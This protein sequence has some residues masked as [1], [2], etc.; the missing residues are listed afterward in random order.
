MFSGEGLF[1]TQ[2]SG[3][4]VAFIT[5]FLFVVYL[6]FLVL[7]GLGKAMF[8]GEGLFVSKLAGKGLAFITTV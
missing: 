4:G 1:V 8:S 6:C 2:L 5:I 3:N 7:Q